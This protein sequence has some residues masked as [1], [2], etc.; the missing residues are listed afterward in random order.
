VQ[1]S[2]GLESRRLEPEHLAD[3]FTAPTP[4]EE[5]AFAPL[6][7]VARSVLGRARAVPVVRSFRPESLH[8]VLLVGRD[9]DRER[10][11]LE[12]AEAA[13]GPWAD[14]LDT[15]A[16][17]EAVPRFV[18]NADNPGVRR[19]ADAG[20]SALQRVA[21]EALYSH[22]LLA[23]RHPLTPFD[24]ALVARALPALIDRAIDGGPA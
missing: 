22:A 1:H 14:A 16:E 5:A 20:D 19:L 8:A 18:L 23:G 9:A 11:R 7:D 21:V 3:R 10:D 2:P 17:P 4:A 15:L 24:S 6:L 12:V 13:Q